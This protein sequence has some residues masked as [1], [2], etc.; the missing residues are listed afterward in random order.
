MNTYELTIVIPGNASAQKKKSAGDTVEKLIKVNKGTI[1]DT[2]DLGKIEL[3]FPIKKS[4]SGLFMRYE[5][6]L[7]G[8]GAKS[9]NNRL[10]AEEEF[11]RYLLV[12]QDSKVIHTKDTK[13]NENHE[14][15]TKMRS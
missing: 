1:K 8:E 7:D 2:K 9:I 14:K 5:V 4:D 12:K 3:A 6:E 15:G 11:I 10:R 13:K